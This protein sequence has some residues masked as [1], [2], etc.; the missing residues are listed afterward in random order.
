MHS[1]PIRRI[2]IAD[3]DNCS[4]TIN[5]E[6][7]GK[8]LS[9]KFVAHAKKAKYAAFYVC[10]HRT[11]GNY[12]TNLLD[13]LVVIEK[14]IERN[15]AY[16]NQAEAR[17]AHR[18]ADVPFF[19]EEHLSHVF[20]HKII[21]HLEQETGLTCIAVSTPGDVEQ[22][23]EAY[24]KIIKPLEE[25]AIRK[26]YDFSAFALVDD[27]VFDGTSKNQQL[28]KVIEDVLAR[29][30][31][32]KQVFDFVD[33]RLDLCQ[34]ALALCDKLPKNVVLNVFHHDAFD[35]TR[36][37]QLNNLPMTQNNYCNFFTKVA[38]ITTGIAAVAYVA[39]QNF[40]A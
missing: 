25:E 5:Q 26:N 37:K 23:G 2:L 22:C 20:T 6:V 28:M 1:R 14:N 15:Q 34:A 36:L 16:E 4:F 3:L 35:S 40:R 24:T 18:Y 8:L 21:E 30:P 10:T 17:E 11:A 19:T 9:R 13:P 31:D 38:A 39:T 27:V 33:D 32:E 29:H 7:N 12:K